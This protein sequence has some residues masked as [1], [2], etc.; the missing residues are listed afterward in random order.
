M[1]PYIMFNDSFLQLLML[2]LYFLIALHHSL[3]HLIWCLIAT[4]SKANTL[5][6]FP[7]EY[8]KL[9]KNSLEFLMYY[10]ITN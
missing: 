7:Q 6:A 4:T 10:C 5:I 3:M 8:L 1:E 9:I 2:E